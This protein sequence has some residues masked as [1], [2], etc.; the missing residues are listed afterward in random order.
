[1]LKCRRLL[2][3][4]ALA[5][6]RP[7]DWNGRPLRGGEW[8]GIHEPRIFTVFHGDEEVQS[9]RSR[10]V[11][12]GSTLKRRYF[13]QERCEK[14]SARKPFSWE[15]VDEPSHLGVRS[16]RRRA[17]GRRRSQE[18]TAKRQAQRE[19]ESTDERGGPCRRRQKGCRHALRSDGESC[20]TTT[21][22][23][24]T[25]RFLGARATDIKMSEI[26]DAMQARKSAMNCTKQSLLVPLGGKTLLRDKRE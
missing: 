22:T 2:E 11:R 6:V 12:A 15:A 4:L 19:A 10:S 26:Q 23:Q 25:P 17:V 5:S 20:L 21:W 14:L 8:R 1:M 18:E 9:A 3:S 13:F 7:P 16:G 24:T